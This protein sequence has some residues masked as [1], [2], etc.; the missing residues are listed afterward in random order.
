MDTD[1][2][3]DETL[4]GSDRLVLAGHILEDVKDAGLSSGVHLVDLDPDVFAKAA[5][6]WNT[7][8]EV[9]DSILDSARESDVGEPSHQACVL[10]FGDYLVT[11]WIFREVWHF[12]VRARPTDR[13][14]P[15]PFR[16]SD[17]KRGLAATLSSNAHRI[18][19]PLKQP[20]T[21]AAG[22]ARWKWV[23][24]AR[25]ALINQVRD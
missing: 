7:V 1:A 18:G 15:P 14:F 16:N 25:T 23:S 8:F 20:G 10:A 13:E 12:D 4:G 17:A 24:D 3:R 9:G 6:A 5:K 11:R 21:F 2:P 19:A 22:S